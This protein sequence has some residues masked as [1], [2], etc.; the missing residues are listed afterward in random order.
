MLRE[1]RVKVWLDRGAIAG[2]MRRKI[3]AAL[4]V[5]FMPN[6]ALLASGGQRNLR[7]AREKLGRSYPIL[8]RLNAVEKVEGG[9]TLEDALALSRFLADEGVDA[10]D[11]SLV[12]QSSWR[13]VEGQHVLGLNPPEEKLFIGVDEV[14]TERKGRIGYG[15][16]IVLITHGRNLGAQPELFCRYQGQIVRMLHPPRGLIV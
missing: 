12:A 15:G 7:A 14:R 4:E 11:V 10:L 8:F 16:E 5:P 2:V 1:E 3:A 9:Q 6:K 13:E